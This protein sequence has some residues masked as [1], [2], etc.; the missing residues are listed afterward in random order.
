MC[1]YFF[2]FVLVSGLRFLFGEPWSLY[3]VGLWIYANKILILW[4]V[5]GNNQ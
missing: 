4:Y 2:F 3:V 5:H 1:D